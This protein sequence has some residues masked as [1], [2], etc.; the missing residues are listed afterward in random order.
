MM[1]N[2]LEDA[3]KTKGWKLRHPE[4]WVCTK[5]AAALYEGWHT[6]LH[7]FN[8]TL[9]RINVRSKKRKTDHKH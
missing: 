8:E 2:S 4:K 6:D 9:R 7:V 3:N 1:Q 5:H